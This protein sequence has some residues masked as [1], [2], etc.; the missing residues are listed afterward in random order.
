MMGSLHRFENRA[1]QRD[2][3]TPSTDADCR[4]VSHSQDLLSSIVAE[5]QWVNQ[6]RPESLHTVSELL[7][8]LKSSPSPSFN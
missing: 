3:Q 7:R 4:P 8:F 1:D 2:S 6:H 5:L